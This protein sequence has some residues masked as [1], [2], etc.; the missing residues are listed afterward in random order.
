M[1]KILLTAGAAVLVFLAVLIWQLPASWL[2]SYLPKQVVCADLAGTAWNGQC[3]ALVF[4][5]QAIGDVTWDVSPLKALTGRVVGDVAVTRVNAAVTATLALAF[6]GDGE[7]TNFKARL[8]LEPGLAPGV[9]NNL[10]GEITLDFQ[11]IV[12]TQR[13]PT[14]LRGLASARNLSRLDGGGFALGNYDLKFDGVAAEDGSHTGQLADRGGPL[15]VRGTIKLTREP[16]YEVTGTV[17]ARAEAAAS[18]RR[19]LELLGAP[20]ARGEREFSVAGAL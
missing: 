16:G 6:S 11:R 5:G 20:N 7:L 1:K 14:E 2:R 13:W 19:Q 3:V 17:A 15:A 4:N 9:P 10:S 8:P 12:M 18:L